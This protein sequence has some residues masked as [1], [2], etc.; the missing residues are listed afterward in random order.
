MLSAKVEI[1]SVVLVAAIFGGVPAWVLLTESQATMVHDPA[2]ARVITLTAVADGGIWTEEEVV[3]HNY[4]HR[5]PK[6]ARPVVRVGESVVI[7]LKSADVS[8]SFS[9]P[10]LDVGPVP[11]DPGH[12]SEVRF[13]PQ[14]PGEHL[15]QCSTRCG[16]CHEEML[17]TIVVL[18]PGQTL[19]DYPGGPLPPRTKCLHH[20]EERK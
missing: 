7:R 12:V 2:N 11:V 10:N 19:A 6:P 4:W 13:V 1:M 5:R 17:G 18:G 3:G 16:P 8:H 20:S 9:I 14:E 15:T